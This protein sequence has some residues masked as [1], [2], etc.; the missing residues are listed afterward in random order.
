MDR[1][2][3]SAG[4]SHVGTRFCGWPAAAVLADVVEGSAGE[5]PGATAIFRETWGSVVACVVG[6]L[7]HAARAGDAAELA[8]ERG[9]V[10]RRRM[11]L[12]REPVE[13]MPDAGADALD[14]TPSA[15][16]TR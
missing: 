14:I 9:A 3:V 5:V 1:S 11:A 13:L 16:G 10:G 15:E 2:A 12:D 4:K 7:H 8:G 6:G